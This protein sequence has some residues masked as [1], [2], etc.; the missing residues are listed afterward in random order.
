MEKEERIYK[1]KSKPW[2]RSKLWRNWMEDF[3][4]SNLR[5][6]NHKEL[7]S[8]K[9]GFNNAISILSKRIKLNSILVK[10]LNYELPEMKIRVVELKYGD[11][12]LNEE[13]F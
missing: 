2:D 6:P 5:P 12:E 8:Y 13:D 4:Q 3:R 9:I 7:L 11:Y 1:L 10:H